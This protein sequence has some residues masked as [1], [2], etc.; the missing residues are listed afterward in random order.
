VRRIR[1]ARQASTAEQARNSR[2]T[3]ARLRVVEKLGSGL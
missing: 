1:V 3:S 2:S